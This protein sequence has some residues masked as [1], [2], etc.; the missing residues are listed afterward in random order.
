[1]IPLSLLQGGGMLCAS[2]EC[3]KRLNAMLIEYGADPFP[4]A[5][6]IQPSPGSL[7]LMIQGWV[8]GLGSDFGFS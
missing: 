7:P 1:M 3:A 6:S 8:L 4:K 5:C 2:S